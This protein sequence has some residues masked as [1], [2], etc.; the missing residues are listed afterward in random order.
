MVDAPFD[1]TVTV[2]FVLLCI[3][4]HDARAQQAPVTIRTTVDGLPSNTINRIVRDSR[5][6][7]WFCTAE[8]LS[9]FD[10]YAFTNFGS[11]Q[12]LPQS[13]INDF[14]ET[15]TGE[16]WI[17]TDGGLVRFNPKG[18]A[19]RRVAAGDGSID[20]VPMFTLLMPDHEGSPSIAVTILRRRRQ[21]RWAGTGDGLYDDCPQP[22]WLACA[23]DTERQCRRASC[24]AGGCGRSGVAS[25][26]GLIAGGLTAGSRY[27]GKDGP[28]NDY[29]Q[30]LLEDH[31]G[32]LWRR[33]WPRFLPRQRRAIAPAT[34]G[35]SPVHGP[36]PRP[37]G[38]FSS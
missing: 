1:E 17:A 11:D 10:G 12:G 28:P 27:T 7:L 9:R 38:C 25:P 4:P 13:P 3:I 30:D 8:G 23:I 15:R 19:G 5:G 29:L 22:S 16:Y 32:H 26:S 2:L 21:A 24:D 6:F 18:R 14:L 37:R 34:G 35:R 36:R 33:H 20:P 31:D